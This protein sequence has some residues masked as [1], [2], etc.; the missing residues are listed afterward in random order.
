MAKS[1][2]RLVLPGENYAK[3]LFDG[4]SAKFKKESGIF[5]Y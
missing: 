4:C 3:K 2:I 1:L 5:N